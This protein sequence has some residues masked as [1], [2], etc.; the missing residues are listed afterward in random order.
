MP[1]GV[2]ASKDKMNNPI[3]GSQLGDL[4]QSQ[5]PQMFAKLG[6]KLRGHARILVGLVV[7]MKANSGFQQEHHVGGGNLLVVVLGIVIGRRELV[8]FENV[9]ISV[10]SIV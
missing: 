8:H 9:G 4:F 5:S 2:S 6:T 10:G 7:G 1:L 3:H